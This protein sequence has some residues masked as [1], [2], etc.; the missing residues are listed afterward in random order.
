MRPPTSPDPRRRRISRITVALVAAGA[1]TCGGLALGGTASAAPAG[2][3]AADLKLAAPLRDAKPQKTIAAFVR[4]T[5][6]GVLAVDAK[7]KGGD[8]TRSKSPSTAAK[9]RLSAVTSTVAKVRAAVKQADSD[10]T[11][12]YATEYTV[13]GVAVV[14]DVE[15]LRKIAAR[16]DVAS[17]VPLTPKKIVDPTVNERSDAAPSGVDPSTTKPGADGVSPKNAASDIYTRSLD[18][19][20]QTGRTGEGVNVA[21]LD[22]GLDYTQADFG[23][24]GTTAAYDQALASTSTPDPSWYDSS[25]FLGGYD[26]A[27]PTYN[28]DPSAE[29][30]DPVPAPDENPIDGKGGDHG[31]HVAGT[32]A[33]FGLNA[34]KTTFRGDYPSLTN[35]DVQDM[36][37]GPG[38]APQAGLYALKVFGDGGGSTDLTGAALD[39][40][41]QA[42]TEGKDINVINLSLGSDY[43]APDDPDNAKMDALTDRG[44]LPVIASGNADDFTDIGGSPGNAEGALTVA[45][46][47]T[48]Q[49]LYDGVEVTTPAD[50]ADTYRAQYSQNYQGALPVEGDV[51]VPTTNV[52]GCKPFSATEAAAIAGKVV[53]LKWTDGALECGSGVRF[54]NVEAAGGIGALL[55]GTINTFDSGIAGNA[56]IP[57][58]EL[59][60]DSV[61][62]LQ[63]AARAGSLH[64][65]FADEL[66]GFQLATDADAVNTLAQFTSRGVHGSFDDIVKPDIAGPGVNVISAANGTGDDRMSMSGT[67]MATPHVAGVAALTFQAHPGWSA[68]E[69]KAALMNTATHDV[70]DGDGDATLLR[71]GTGRVDALQSVNDTT[72]VRSQE[73]DRL[74]TASF[75]VVEVSGPTTE[76][77][78]LLVRNT[79][80]T[81]HTYAVAYESRVAQSG[82]AFSLSSK[83]VTVPAGGT[84]TVTLTMTITDPTLLRKVADPTQ[85]TVQQGLPREFVPAATGLVTFTSSESGVTPLRLGTYAAPKPVSAVHG[86]D[87]AF[88]GSATSSTIPLSG[89]GL[90]QGAGET[91]YSAL[92]APFV[93]GG[94]DPKEA[95]PDG[96]AKQSLEA[97]D[98]RAFGASSTAVGLADRSTGLVTFGVQTQGADANP[99][100]VTNVEVLIDTDRD[101]TPDFLTYDAKSATVDATFVTTIDLNDTDPDAEPVDVQLLGGGDL[102]Q[103]VNTFDS[104]VKVLPVSLAALGYSKTSKNAAFDYTV[105]TESAY[106]AVPATIGSSVV[107]ETKTATFDAYAPA[108]SFTRGGVSSSVF[109]DDYAIRVDRSATTTSAKVLLLHLHN[110][111]G[112]QAEV[113][114]A[115]GV[116]PKL[117]LESGSTVSITGSS[118]VGSK[119]TAR[120]GSWNTSGITYSYQ[121]LR[122]GSAVSGA[123]KSTYTTTSKDVGHRMQVTVTAKKSGWTSASVTSKATNTVHK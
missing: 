82:V 10:A 35:Q 77:R 38:S 110:A 53:W 69:V 107:D 19:W 29:G 36:W 106:S 78:T 8:L 25:K 81:A 70:R 39:W 83:T 26:F 47:A 108:L 3:S 30:Y 85:E 65:R 66:R 6:E 89:R 31:T 20:Q 117:A 90:S 22:T 93:L 80:D 91:G 118:T 95:F 28:A 56:T 99:G 97:A 42:L 96:T 24:P 41:G 59:T 120:V 111:V 113:L 32:A 55:A 112:D 122:D 14:A 100:A 104:A 34:D 5:G 2:L 1:L 61:T 87:V 92:A 60:K 121:W 88:R 114:T 46:S 76:K 50:V 94:T 7:A 57:G 23:G 58:A 98:V 13:P 62:S 11:E 27:G 102:G 45:A 52:D 68:A 101:G 119:F 123:T 44:V 51:V 109:P 33:G 4:T 103:D 64:V 73:N 79:D 16:S 84:A 72:T 115:S 40:V 15:A 37:I 12:L 21:V 17:V 71:Q 49:S 9:Q 67:S 43:G 105:L 63:A 18:A 48:G 86:D 54:N 116:T 75:G 74:V